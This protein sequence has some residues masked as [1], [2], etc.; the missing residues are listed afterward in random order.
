MV[1]SF[2][3]IGADKAAKFR[4]AFSNDVEA[5]TLLEEIKDANKELDNKLKIIITKEGQSKM[6]ENTNLDQQRIDSINRLAKDFKEEVKGVDLL[7]RAKLFVDGGKSANDFSD[8]I[9]KNL[10][11]KVATAKPSVDLPKS[12]VEKYSITRGIAHIL[13]PSLGNC[14]EMEIS[15]A[16]QAATG[17]ESGGFVIPHNLMDS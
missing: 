6:D 16:Y 5:K 7:S 9:M 4:S 15:R 3:P 17:V 13:N 2:V 12:V 1:N 8:F 11:E 10:E 14:L